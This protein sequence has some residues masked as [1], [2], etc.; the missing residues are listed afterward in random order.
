MFTAALSDS[1]HQASITSLAFLAVRPFAQAFVQALS[2]SSRWTSSGQPNNPLEGS[3]VRTGLHEN[4]VAPSCRW[5][6]SLPSCLWS[7]RI[8]PSLLGSCLTI[9]YRDASSAIVQLVDQWFN[10]TYTRSHAFRCCEKK[11]TNPADKNRTHDFRTS[12]VCMLPTRPLGRRYCTA[13]NVVR[14]NPFPP[15][16]S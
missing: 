11:N 12:R 7:L 14:D 2:T 4:V 16:S 8:F 15:P 5:T 3:K 10:F 9:V 6:S 13:E 1:C